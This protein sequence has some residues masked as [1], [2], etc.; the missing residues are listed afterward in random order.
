MARY[1]C[2]R[3]T[4]GWPRKLLACLLL[5][6]AVC[7]T[8]IDLAA[9]AAPDSRETDE[10]LF[11]YPNQWSVYWGDQPG[12]DAV[13]EKLD[14]SMYDRFAEYRGIVWFKR[15]LPAL[16]S[17]DPYLFL[18]DMHRITV[19]IDGVQ[20]YATDNR[21]SMKYAHAGMSFQPIPLVADDAGKLVTIR[22]EWDRDQLLPAWNIIGERF[23]LL[24]SFVGADWRLLVVVVVFLLAGSV[25]LVMFIRVP[26][27]RIF[28]WFTLLAYSAGIGIGLMMSTLQ[29][30]GDFRH[31]FYWRDL[32]LPLGIL[33][34]VGFYGAAQGEKHRR[35]Y[36][37]ATGIMLT[38]TIAAAVSAIFNHVLY[39]EMLLNGLPFCFAV[40][41]GIVTY[42][43]FRGARHERTAEMR[44]LVGGYVVLL[45]SGTI[46]ISNNIP[47]IRM[48]ILH[49]FPGPIGDYVLQ[50]LPAGLLMFAACLTVVVFRR[51]TAMLR[52]LRQYAEQ[53]TAAH[54]EM[55]KFDRLKDDFLR[56]TSHELRTPLHGIAGLTES[57]LEGAAGSV[58]PPMQ[59]NLRLIR[60]SANRLLHLVNDI[61]DLYR[62]QHKDVTLAPA[63]TDA[64]AVTEAV[65]AALAPLA[66]RKGLALGVSAE[67]P[68]PVYVRADTNRLEQILYNLIGNA[69]RYTVVG[70]VSVTLEQATESVL[71]HV[72]DT[73]PG[74]PQER[75]ET[76]FEPFAAAESAAG[77]GTGLGLSIAKRLVQLHGGSI[78]VRSVP[79]EG[80]RVSFSLLATTERPDSH[81][82]ALV[83]VVS[84]RYAEEASAAPVLPLAPGDEEAAAAAAP[85]VQAGNGD[86]NEAAERLI[87]IVDDEPINVQVL[88]HYLRGEACRLVHAQD[89]LEALRLLDS[90]IKPDLLLLDVMMPGMTGYD[91]CRRIRQTHGPSDLP[92]ILLSARNRVSDLTEG[93]DAG[94]NDYL[95]KPFSQGEL[96][97]RVRIQLK[98]GEF[99]ESLEKLVGIRTT[100]LADRTK[101]LEELAETLV[102]RTL[103]LEDRTK[104]LEEA[105]TALAGS[106]R[107]T[108]EALAEVSVWEERNRIAHEIHDVVG[109][110]LTATIVQL[111][112]ARKLA[113]RDL[114]KSVEKLDL[115]RDSVRKGLDEIRRSVRML[116]DEGGGFDLTVALQEL[117]TET[118]C[119]TGVS[120]E[121]R[122]S[123]LPQVSELMG[124]V[125]YHSLMEGITNGI[126]HGRC[127]AFAFE[128]Y[129]RE[130]TLHFRLV[131]DGVVYGSSRPGFG[132]TALMERVHLLGG[133]VRIGAADAA[134]LPAAS[135]GAAA[136]GNPAGC[137]LTITLPLRQ[138]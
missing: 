9:A 97:A 69:I 60:N 35:P 128:L 90:G 129:A 51:Y 92:V 95:S 66:R 3:L 1:S 24:R 14:A 53:L 117:I 125:V 61:L 56:N 26:K 109:H 33:A 133:T 91:V 131:N 81:T 34:F 99:H 101:E 83:E 71:I 43:L 74:I 22:A 98:L 58:A 127:R 2:S 50:V 17:R 41:L 54:E 62:L 135:G 108:A 115:A 12:A 15:T 118:T 57:L 39:R 107:E 77:G 103:E 76:L 55:V 32:L 7:L 70:S 137:A 100:E 36:R 106:V 110:T 88:V 47:I 21:L 19:F 65:T 122:I 72:T 96:L 80:T 52:R 126:R 120:F 134:E 30:F 84:S 87:M 31:L 112:A 85:A 37:F 23:A 113:D 27:E 138:E 78:A 82:A 73:G 11:H 102:G 114:A 79:G 42:T 116:K 64:R 45:L 136:A 4:A 132:L 44:W 46:H 124:R 130:N 20:V 89:G 111:E 123:A 93:F 29:W 75:M 104:E 16:A 48:W 25:S 68:G 18:R 67:R 59:D 28:A 86:G 121:R 6:A 5:A 119:G 63:P 40:V 38:F 105:N 94:A 8:A 10:R 49:A 13:W